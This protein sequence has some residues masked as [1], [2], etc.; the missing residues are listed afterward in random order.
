MHTQ[1]SA[2]CPVLPNENNRMITPS[3]RVPISVVVVSCLVHMVP[4]VSSELLFRAYSQ[5]E[6]KRVPWG[7]PI[8]MVEFNKQKTNP[9]W[10]CVHAPICA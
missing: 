3:F 7:L 8:D 1:Y 2:N 6:P 5:C 9:S 4:H 10:G